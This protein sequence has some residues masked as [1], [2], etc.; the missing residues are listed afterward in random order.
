[1]LLTTLVLA[2]LALP[3]ASG[4]PAPAAPAKVVPM[5]VQVETPAKAD[6]G[7]QSWAREL[8][9]ALEARKDEFHLVRPGEKPELVV[10]VD[11]L[12]KAPDGTLVMNGALVLGKTKRDFAY[13]YKDVKVQAEALARNLRKFADQMKSSG[14]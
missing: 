12:G 8:R 11:S 1:M 13:G 4:G 10:R 9:A 3:Q 6:E 5:S 7:T 14:K 2:A